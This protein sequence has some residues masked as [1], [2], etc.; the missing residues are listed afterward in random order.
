MSFNNICD[1]DDTDNN[2][3]NKDNNNNAKDNNNNAKDYSYIN[4]NS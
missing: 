1:K 3:I 4:N 2:N